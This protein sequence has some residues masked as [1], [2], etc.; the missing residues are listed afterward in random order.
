MLRNAGERRLLAQF[1]AILVGLA[2]AAT[3]G[4]PPG[5]ADSGPEISRF[6]V[7]RLIV[8]LLPR[9]ESLNWLPSN[10]G[11]DGI[12]LVEMQNGERGQFC[13]GRDDQAGQ[14]GGP[15][16]PLSDLGLP[17]HE[18]RAPQELVGWVRS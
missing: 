5:P 7:P 2:K 17:P 4:D 10:L 11:D 13:G 9:L 8:S 1:P 18:R 14:A 12:I 3:F 15:G 6:Q 16:P